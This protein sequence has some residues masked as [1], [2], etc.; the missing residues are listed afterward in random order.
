MP[1]GSTTR[2]PIKL[3]ARQAKKQ[4]LYGGDYKARA[5]LVR[6]T[7]TNCYL[8]GGP[9]TATDLPEAD[10]LYPELGNQSPLLAAHGVCNRRKGNRNLNQL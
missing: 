2:D 8:C 1:G 10:H 9:F 7:A 4:H 3:Q 6:A 5:K